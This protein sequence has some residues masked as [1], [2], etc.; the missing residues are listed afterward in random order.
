[1]ENSLEFTEAENKIRKKWLFWSIKLPAFILGCFFTIGVLSAIITT[2]LMAIMGLLL[3][4]FLSV[5][6]LYMNYYCAYKNAGTILLL[7]EMI[8]SSFSLVVILFES[9][10]SAIFLLYQLIVFYY[11]YKLRKINKKFQERN[12]IASPA[13]INALSVFST[14]T[15]L[16][17]LNEQFS[18]L[19]DLESS[20]K[21]L[22][23]AYKQQKKRLKLASFN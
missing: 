20:V 18:K 5:C 17:E 23:K 22:T 16:K 8:W 14:A 1:M 19:R 15:N 4:S 10:M 11:S 21:A 9:E 12:L 13:Y 2:N 6:G 7:F 3:A